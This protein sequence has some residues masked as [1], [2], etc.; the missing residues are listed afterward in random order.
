MSQP[1]FA[2]V[3]SADPA[4]SVWVVQAFR[5]LL[6]V[7]MARGGHTM[8][9]LATWVNLP[10]SAV[11]RA[12]TGE[13]L[14]PWEVYHEILAAC[15]A[16]P[17]R[18]AHIRRRW[19]VARNQIMHAQSAPGRP[20]T[21]LEESPRERSYLELED[22]EL[23][24]RT[25]AEFAQLLNRIRARAG[26][27]CGQIATKA[28]IPRSQAYSL[29]DKNRTTLPT[30]RSQ[31]CAFVEACGLHP[32]QVEGVMRLWSKLLEAKTAPAVPAENTE[33]RLLPVMAD[34][35]DPPIDQPV[36]ISDP[37]TSPAV[38]PP[39]G[40]RPVR[41]QPSGSLRPILVDLVSDHG[42]GWHRTWRLTALL[43]TILAVGMA[44]V[45]IFFVAAVNRL[46]LVITALIIGLAA[47]IS[48]FLALSIRPRMPN[49][50]PT[51]AVKPA[52]VRRSTHA[53]STISVAEILARE[54]SPES[55]S[56]GSPPWLRTRPYLEEISD[57]GDETKRPPH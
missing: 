8:Q 24:A 51:P 28:K 48:G 16:S 37:E 25:P 14:L 7:E 5:D 23:L 19:S 34:E 4:A 2:Q 26:L 38:G 36:D 46:G 1:A 41:A 54:E 3:P 13:S 31:V 18:Q 35:A 55:R 17:A 49:S 40:G 10:P 52:A 56:A 32:H 22:A 47:A 53:R 11:R 6:Q 30:K 45:S 12:I 21:Q 57:D 20:R 29:V 43:F 39:A 50:L 15:G 42:D 27:T 9:S 44:T 33:P